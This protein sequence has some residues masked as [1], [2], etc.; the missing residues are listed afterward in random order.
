MPQ[1]TREGG[2]GCRYGTTAARAPRSVRNHRACLPP[3]HDAFCL[4]AKPEDGAASGNSA[5][6]I[7]VQGDSDQ[8][9]PEEGGFDFE[10]DDFRRKAMSEVM[11][12]ED[13]KGLRMC[14]L[15]DDSTHRPPQSEAGPS[16][17]VRLP[18]DSDHESAPSSKKR[19]GV[20]DGMVQAEI[21]KR[22]R[23]SIG[24]DGPGKALGSRSGI[25]ASTE[26]APSASRSVP[27]NS[28]ISSSSGDSPAMIG[29]SVKEDFTGLGVP[30]LSSTPKCEGSWACGVCTL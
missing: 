21:A 12:D 1:Q 17:P 10:D 5:G 24:M 29:Q 11:D 14:D 22:K 16:H 15:L 30:P 26:R 8:S 19:K 23:E 18:T 7:S 2:E 25:K 28:D 3:F 6:S 13:M 9:D 20:L 27:R 4:P